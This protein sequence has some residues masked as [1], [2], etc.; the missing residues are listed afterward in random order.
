MVFAVS[1]AAFSQSTD[2]NYC[3]ALADA[4]RKTNSQ[5]M[6]TTVREAINQCNQGNAAAGISVLEKAL[7]EAK[8]ALPPRN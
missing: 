4:Y 3:Q 8:V 1:F 7:K 5:N 2:A 6:D